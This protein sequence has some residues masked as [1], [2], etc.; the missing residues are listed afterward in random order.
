MRRPLCKCGVRYR[1]GLRPVTVVRV[2]APQ[3]ALSLAVFIVAAL[4]DTPASAHSCG[5]HHARIEILLSRRRRRSARPH[6]SHNM[7]ACCAAASRA[8]LECSFA[9]L[10]SCPP[11]AYAWFFFAH[12]SVTPYRL[13]TRCLGVTSYA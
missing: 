9:V 8:E 4:D 13:A 11:I 6:A 5:S 2:Y 12:A 3:P 1:S 7:R 10:L